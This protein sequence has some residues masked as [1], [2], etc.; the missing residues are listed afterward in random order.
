MRRF[1]VLCLIV[2]IFAISF[3]ASAASTELDWASYANNWQRYQQDFTVLYR[4]PIGGEVRSYVDIRLVRTPAGT[5]Q[6]HKHY[7]PSE[8][9][10]KGRQMLTSHMD[11]EIHS[12][13]I[14][15]E[16]GFRFAPTLHGVIADG[17][18]DKILV[19]D[20]IDAPDLFSALLSDTDARLHPS[21][22]DVL[23][24]GLKVFM[25]VQEFHRLG[26]SHGDL[27]P[28]NILLAGGVD[29]EIHLIDFQGTRQ[30]NAPGPTAGT[31]Q[32]AS[33][34]MLTQLAGIET[35]LDGFADDIWSLAVLFHLL[36]T[37]WHPLYFLADPDDADWGSV[38]D[39]QMMYVRNRGYPVLENRIRHV[40]TFAGC[41][42]LTGDLV[43]LIRSMTSLQPDKRIS[44]DEAVQ[45][46]A[47]IVQRAEQLSVGW[48][49]AA[50]VG[51]TLQ[52]PA[53]PGPGRHRPLWQQ[54]RRRSL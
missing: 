41:S 45:L 48:P 27:K 6:V 8:M 16:L 4:L 26:L 54:R 42:E 24:I 21:P 50:A 9:S 51:A 7:R 18:Q 44:V 35:Q 33:P 46:L 1:V 14:L 2:W 49:N 10:A 36:L 11:N 34:Q 37:D 12:L 19:M 15:N 40:L 13:R 30:R 39:I 38:Q 28:E 52:R 29:G 25:R 47:D 32:Y 20:Y 5:V 43:T 53:A 31:F 17:E 22:L 23:K 3:R